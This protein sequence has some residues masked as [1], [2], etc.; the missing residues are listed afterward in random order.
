MV[1]SLIKGGAFDCTGMTRSTMLV[2][3][4]RVVAS[5]DA[6]RKEKQRKEES[7]QF[8]IF[9]ILGASFVQKEEP[10]RYDYIP[11]Y[12]TRETLIAEKEMLG[13]YVSGHPLAGYEEEFSTFTFNT[14]MIPSKKEDDFDHDVDYNEHVENQLSD[15][16]EVTIGGIIA[17]VQKKRTKSGGDMAIVLL[18]D[19]YDRI[20]CVCVGRVMTTSKQFLENDK[21]VRI[22]G[23]LSI[24]DDSYSIFVSELKPWDLEEKE[25]VKEIK[26]DRILYF[27]L[28]KV[29]AF[30]FD[31]VISRIDSI[32]S[33]HPGPNVV[34]F[35]LDKA[36]H[37][38]NKTICNPDVVAKEL[39]GILGPDNI[40]IR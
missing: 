14:S 31:D 23:R 26:D 13:M 33:A 32:I 7:G 12:P 18:E 2:N 8:D 11:E 37:L 10:F 22:K 9:D 25:P 27:N 35:Q 1:E 24:R 28:E 38:Y 39:M 16:M 5:V 29:E 36:L 40:K 34:K 3:L 30:E 6:K 4:E 21:L 19:M 20:E 17:N 15:N